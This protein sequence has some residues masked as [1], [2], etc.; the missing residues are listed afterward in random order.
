MGFF[1][2]L[3][4]AIGETISDLSRD[5][6]SNEDTWHS[7]MSS[8][9]GELKE[10]KQYMDVFKEALAHIRAKRPDDTYIAFCS[11]GTIEC[12]EQI[13][14]CS[15]ND[16]IN[17]KDRTGHLVG[18]RIYCGKPWEHKLSFKLWL[19][20][21]DALQK[22][23]DG[24]PLKS[25]FKYE[26]RVV[27]EELLKRRSLPKLTSFLGV[28]FGDDYQKYCVDNAKIL[29]QENGLIAIPAKTNRLLEFT[30]YYIIKP[31]DGNDV[32]GVACT[33]DK[34]NVDDGFVSRVIRILGEK[35]QRDCHRIKST[36]WSTPRCYSLGKS[37][38]SA[39]GDHVMRFFEDEAKDRWIN[40]KHE[41]FIDQ[42]DKITITA[43][44]VIAAKKAESAYR[45]AKARETAQEKAETER[46]KS[47]KYEKDRSSAMDAL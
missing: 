36:D 42:E 1:G 32:I 20:T 47:E 40:P 2:E 7:Y 30:S 15:P 41:I 43:I 13:D 10:D 28:N 9:T 12:A 45:D 31:F 25:M 16:G 11:A 3:F 33:V 19:L 6:N 38:K 14:G 26:T 39:E 46:K 34:Q 17:G 27:G 21:P 29:D 35:Y 8:V 23:A 22:G 37:V 18:W 4:G 44:D 24:K 5:V